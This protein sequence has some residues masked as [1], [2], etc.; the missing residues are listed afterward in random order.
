MNL[1]LRM[2]AEGEPYVPAAA[3]ELVVGDGQRR[4]A[5]RSETLFSSDGS[6]PTRFYRREK[7]VPGDKLPLGPA[8]ITEYTAAMLLPP[9]ASALVDG[10]RKPGD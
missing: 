6:R 10:T 7:L 8:M 4:P 1:R 9:G 3:H 5:T 2:T